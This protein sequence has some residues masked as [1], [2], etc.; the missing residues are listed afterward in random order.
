MVH[1]RGVLIGE[2]E[3]EYEQTMESALKVWEKRIF[4]S[5][6]RLVRRKFNKRER[7]GMGIFSFLVA[8]VKASRNFFP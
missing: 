2:K 4:A 8:K 7:S 1:E 6:A 5:P 3:Y